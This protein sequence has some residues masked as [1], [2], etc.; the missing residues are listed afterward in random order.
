M[1]RGIG[2]PIRRHERSPCF[3]GPTCSRLNAPHSARAPGG[4][5]MWGLSEAA[6]SRMRYKH[7]L[8]PCQ[9]SIYAAGVSAPTAGNSCCR[10]KRDI[11]VS[12]MGGPWDEKYIIDDRYGFRS[13]LLDCQIHIHIAPGLCQE[14]RA[15]GAAETSRL[16]SPI[17]ASGRIG[18][19]CRP[20]STGS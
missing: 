2:E 15:R 8:R 7:V 9:S 13:S 4:R 17:P 16:W 1:T 18:A 12:P 3:D 14:P 11:P 20:S 6:Q 19:P 10:I 5:Y